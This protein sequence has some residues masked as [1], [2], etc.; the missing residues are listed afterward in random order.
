LLHADPF[1]DMPRELLILRHAKSDWDSG[2][3][4][5]FDRPLAKRGRKDAPRVGAW[6]YREGMVPDLVVS[7]PAER[8]RETALKVC[9]SMDLK[10]K[11]IVWD[12]DVYD[13]G[14]G[15][16]LGVLARCPPDA[17]V[18][19]LVGHNPGLEELLT[20]LAGEEAEVPA[21][22][23]LL[24]T[25]ALARLEMPDDW[26]SLPAGCAQLVS[27]TRPRKPKA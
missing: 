21:D 15:Q 1:S 17:S 18:V 27:I 12:D 5:D 8:A 2:A 14:L 11:K 16:L 9:K 20:Y 19:L 25:A 22:G 24:P 7:S 3:S 10:K 4:R 13:A 6:L 26:S 23:K